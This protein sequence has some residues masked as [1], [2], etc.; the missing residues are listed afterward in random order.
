M[1]KHRILLT[2]SSP[3]DKEDKFCQK[4]TY[5]CILAPQESIS[6]YFPLSSGTTYTKML[7]I[8]KTLDFSLNHCQPGSRLGRLREIEICLFCNLLHISP[9]S[10]GRCQDKKKKVSCYL[11]Q[12]GVPR[13]NMRKGVCVKPVQFL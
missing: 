13:I 12:I 6:T 8:A 7:N 11:K 3:I 1:V 4:Q 2:T 10:Q 5:G 9:F